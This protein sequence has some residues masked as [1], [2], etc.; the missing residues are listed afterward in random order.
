[1][2]DSPAV[3]TDDYVKLIVQS[4][5]AFQAPIDV[6]PGVMIMSEEDKY[7]LLMRNG[8]QFTKSPKP[9]PGATAETMQTL[10]SSVI[11]VE[12]VMA[13]SN[14][15]LFSFFGGK[16]DKAKTFHAKSPETIAKLKNHLEKHATRTGKEIQCIRGVSKIYE[17][18]LDLQNLD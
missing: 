11:K 4:T 3:P 14:I 18:Y 7:F 5:I 12:F 8:R 13:N 2:I 9:P 1:M 10:L 16:P 15:K 17:G 6:L